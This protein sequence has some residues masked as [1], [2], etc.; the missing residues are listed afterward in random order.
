[1]CSGEKK[2]VNLGYVG[3]YEFENNTMV[4]LPK[5]LRSYIYGINPSMAEDWE[6]LTEFFS[7]YNIE[8]NYLDCNGTYGWYDEDLGGWTGCIGKV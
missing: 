3:G 2:I 1:M 5:R 4:H 6:V 7:N 8:P